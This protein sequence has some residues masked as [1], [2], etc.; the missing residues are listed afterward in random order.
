MSPKKRLWPTPRSNTAMASKITPEIANAPNRFPNLETV[1]GREMIPEQEKQT[2]PQLPLLPGDSLASLSVLPGSEK[3]RMTTAGSG[4]KC[5]GLS[6][7]SDPLGVLLKMLLASSEWGSTVVYL[8]WRTRA[9]SPR[10]FLYQLVPSTPPTDEI[11]SSLWPTVCSGEEGT[12]RKNDKWQ[13]YRGID[14]ATAVYNKMWPTPTETDFRTGYGE[15]EAGK[16]R[17]EH[18][19]GDPLRDEVAP[20]GQLNPTWVEGLMGF[21]HGYTDIAEGD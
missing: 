2:T 5:L 16:A 7:R 12:P 13:Q 21:P 20:G 19:R 6:E 8:T 18:P 17:L 3:A 9:I 14:L 15:T 1:V 11:E 10:R 4:L